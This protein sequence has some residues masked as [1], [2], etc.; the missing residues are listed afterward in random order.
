[1]ET[2]VDIPLIRKRLQRS[3]ESIK[4]WMSPNYSSYPALLEL[5]D[6]SRQLEFIENKDLRLKLSEDD[7]F[8]WISVDD[9]LPRENEIVV[10][11]YFR[12]GWDFEIDTGYVE[13][14]QWRLRNTKAVSK[15]RTV[16]YWFPLPHG[17]W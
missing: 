16:K 8:R 10:V 3:I 14:G 11:A 7:R 1:M 15:S 12:K 2:I 4:Q 9:H 6:I 5:Q 17:D 13:N